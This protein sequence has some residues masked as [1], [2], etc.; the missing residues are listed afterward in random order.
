M[1]NGDVSKLYEDGKHRRYSLLFAVNGGTLAIA[2]YL[3]GDLDE[4]ARAVVGGLTVDLL[5]LGMVLFSIVMVWDIYAFGS[6]IHKRDSNLFRFPGRV[7]LCLIGLLIC[8][9]WLIAGSYIATD[10]STLTLWEGAAGVLVVIVV[11]WVIHEI[12]EFHKQRFLR[13]LIGLISNTEDSQQS[14]RGKMTP[15]P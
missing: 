5:S 4:S 6:R 11:T 8:L 3:A 2:K 1:S 14:D 12:P 10:T 15:S 7:V 9:G 13:S